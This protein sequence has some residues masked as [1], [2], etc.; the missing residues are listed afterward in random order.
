MFL[1]KNID[2][3]GYHINCPITHYS[4]TYNY[5]SID[6]DDTY[7]K[8]WDLRKYTRISHYYIMVYIYDITVRMQKIKSDIIKYELARYKKEQS[9]VLDFM[10]NELTLEL[11]KLN[12]ELIIY[13]EKIQEFCYY[14]NHPYMNP[15]NNSLLARYNNIHF[16]YK[17]NL[18]NSVVNEKLIEKSKTMRKLDNIKKIFC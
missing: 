1:A 7:A 14:C 6:E 2:K 17:K 18:P 12:E 15:D 5:E 4:L 3:K 16:D 8:L 13:N 9:K 11:M 10:I